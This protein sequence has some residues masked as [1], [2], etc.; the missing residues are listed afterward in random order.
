MPFII[1]ICTN[2]TLL[3]SAFLVSITIQKTEAAE[4]AAT[5]KKLTNRQK[6]KEK[7]QQKIANDQLYHKK[8]QQAYQEHAQWK[9]QQKAVGQRFMSDK[10]FRVEPKY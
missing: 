8:L 2:K 10:G 4:Q 7:K 3:I 9:R 6:R 1:P 5:S